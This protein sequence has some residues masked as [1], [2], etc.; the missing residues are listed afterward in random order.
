VPIWVGGEGRF[1]QRRAAVHGD[2]WFPYFVRITPAE[3]SRGFDSVRRYA[4]EVGRDPAQIALACCLPIELT[5][6]DVPQEKDYLKGSIPQVT[7]ALRAFQQIGVCHVG[8]Q[9]MLPHWPERQ[10]QIARFA[11]QALPELRS[12]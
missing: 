5:E 12:P 9:F 1:A 2:A 4:G 8:L 11:E 3:L 6:R 7:Q 10:E